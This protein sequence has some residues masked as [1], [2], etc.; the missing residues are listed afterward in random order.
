MKLLLSYVKRYWK[1]IALALVLAAINQTFSL[2]DPLVFRYIID[3]YVTR[4][5]EYTARE[6]FQGAFDG[7]GAVGAGHAGDGEGDLFGRVRVV[8]DLVVKLSVVVKLVIVFTIAVAVGVSVWGEDGEAEY[9]EEGDGADESDSDEQ[10]ESDNGERSDSDLGSAIETEEESDD[11]G[12][13]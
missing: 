10:D 7:G 9:G 4:F 8:A 2:L 13:D 11:D 6:F 3:Q 12:W 5:Q 1:L